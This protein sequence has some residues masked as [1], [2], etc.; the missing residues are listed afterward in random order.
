MPNLFADDPSPRREGRGPRP[1]PRLDRHRRGTSGPISRPSTAAATST[2]RSAASPATARATRPASR[3]RRRSPFAVP[4]GDLKAKYT[5]RQPGGFLE[6]A[7]GPAGR[8]HAAAARRQGGRRTSPT[9]CSRASRSTCRPARARR[10]TRYYEGDWDKLPDFAKLKPKATGTGAGVRPRRR[11]SASRTTRMRFEGFFKADARRR[12]HV[13]PHQRRRLAA[14]R[15]TARRSWTTTASTRRRRSRGKSKLTKGVHKVSVGFFQGGG[16]A[17]LDVRD[18]GPRPRPAAARRRSSPRPRRTW[19]RSRSR[20]DAKDEDALTIKPDLV[21]KGKALFASA[22]LRELPQLKRRTRRRR[23][24]AQGAA[25]LAKLKPAR[26]LPGR[27]ADEGP[28]VVRPERRPSGRRSSRPRSR[29]RQRL[30]GAGRQ[31][32]PGRC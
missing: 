22:G 13:H 7:A 23:L 8:P 14:V 19:T 10:S 4:L 9:T 12:V 29:S 28:A 2:P 16:G 1:L 31:S 6:P 5:D 27:D 26:R 17:E 3:P 30:D 25:P 21:E 24:D 11:R 20:S 18:R 15:S 32:S